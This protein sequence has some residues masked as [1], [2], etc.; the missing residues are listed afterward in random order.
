VVPKQK[1][2]LD[3]FLKTGSIDKEVKNKVKRN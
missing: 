3:S 2:V 1:E